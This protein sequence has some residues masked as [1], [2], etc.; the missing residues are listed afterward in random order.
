MGNIRKSKEEIIEIHERYL[1]DPVLQRLY[2]EMA[3]LAEK[4]AIRYYVREGD[5][6]KAVYSEEVSFLF[7]Q[8]ELMIR[9][10]IERHYPEI[11]YPDHEQPLYFA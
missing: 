5:S 6:L 8:I 3:D 10:H 4:S 7:R 1:S 2:K 11:I 9:Q